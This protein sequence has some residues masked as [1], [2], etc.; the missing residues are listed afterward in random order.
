MK[1]FKDITP[2]TE[3]EMKLMFERIWL[4]LETKLICDVLI[5][6]INLN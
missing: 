4:N 2:P 5:K 1:K 6:N 3:S